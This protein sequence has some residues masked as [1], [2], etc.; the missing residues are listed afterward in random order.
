[1]SIARRRFL[2]TSA[3]AGTAALAG[4]PALV[5]AQQATTWRAQSMWSAA[6]LTYKCFEDFCEHVKRPRTAG[7]SSSRSPPAR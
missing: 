6:E 4:A 1:M 7:S 2:G 3:V 5:R